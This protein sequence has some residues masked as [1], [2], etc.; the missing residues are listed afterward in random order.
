M[1]VSGQAHCTFGSALYQFEL[2][3]LAQD[4]Q[5]SMVFDQILSVSQEMVAFNKCHDI[6]SE[7]AK[8]MLNLIK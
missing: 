5:S 2:E 4:P 7:R 6:S 8:A 3:H 1:L